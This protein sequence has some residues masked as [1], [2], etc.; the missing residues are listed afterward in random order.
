[1][2]FTLFSLVLTF[3]LLSCNQELQSDE[4]DMGKII[5]IDTAGISKNVFYT[6]YTVPS[7]SEQFQH[8]T[9]KIKPIPFKLLNPP[10][11]GK[12]YI[13][14][15]SKLLNFGVYC[16]DAAY[17]AKIDSRV[18]CFKYVI[19][20]Q[21]LSIDLNLNS[22][23][24]DELESLL[25]SMN[26]SKDSL[27]KMADYLYLKTFDQL[28]QN[29]RGSELGLI[30]I[31]AYTELMYLSLN[32]VKEFGESVDVE[33]FLAEQKAVAENLL[34]FLMDYQTEESVAN[35]TKKVANILTIYDGMLCTYSEPKLLKKE[36]QNFLVGGAKCKLTKE[37][38]E[39]L[40]RSVFKLRNQIISN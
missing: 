33:V 9:Q 27:F 22:I 17:S 2:R 26:N 8:L 28:V 19:E 29:Q 21:R 40:K 38:F 13:T 37:V 5:N 34:S 32:Q 14:S 25:V 12:K 11:N 4:K 15:S 35:M 30:L 6:F 7:P 36:N 16:S 18:S 23:L 3:G 39:E 31:G 24:K 1:M 10:E 20:L